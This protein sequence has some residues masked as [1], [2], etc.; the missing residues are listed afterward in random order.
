MTL[1]HP[2]APLFGAVGNREDR[3]HS[4]FR[5][6]CCAGLLCRVLAYGLYAVPPR[7]ANG[8]EV[9]AGHTATRSM[10]PTNGVRQALCLEVMRDSFGRAVRRRIPYGLRGELGDGNRVKQA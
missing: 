3:R 2:V 4:C 5:R 8:Q 10:L 7:E 6:Y 1:S 9:L